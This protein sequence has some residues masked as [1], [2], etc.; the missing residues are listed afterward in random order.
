M[1][2]FLYSC[3][4]IILIVGISQFA[5]MNAQVINI[6]TTWSLDTTKNVTEK[7]PPPSAVGKYVV[8]DDSPKFTDTLEMKIYAL[9]EEAVQLEPK[10]TKS[11][12]MMPVY[13]GSCEMNSLVMARNGIVPSR[14]MSYELMT[15]IFS[16]TNVKMK[17]MV[18]SKLQ[19]NTYYATI[20]L[21]DN[22][23]I[24]GIDARPSDAMNLAL[25]NKVPIYCER[26]VFNEAKEK[27]E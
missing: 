27:K 26:A 7:D 3:L 6:K 4:F 23:N 22:G 8:K 14:P 21:D 19:D 25:R 17:S 24:L 20:I 1:K 10:K 15:S 18:I 12:F 11:D 5:N 16:A 13:I 2:F 9:T